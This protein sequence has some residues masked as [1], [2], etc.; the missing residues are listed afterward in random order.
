LCGEGALYDTKVSTSGE[1]EWGSGREKPKRGIKEKGAGF[2]SPVSKR[3][4]DKPFRTKVHIE[5][6]SKESKG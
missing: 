6:K 3:S 2:L 5:I 1:G 4:G